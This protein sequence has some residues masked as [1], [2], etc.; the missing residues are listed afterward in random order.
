[1]VFGF[2][3]LEQRTLETFLS[4]IGYMDRLEGFRVKPR[5]VH[6]GGNSAWS[7]VEVLDLFGYD[8]VGFDIQG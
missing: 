8:S 7:R 5:V 4:K 2:G 1:M 3:I 6:G